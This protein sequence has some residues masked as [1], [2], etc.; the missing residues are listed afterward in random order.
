MTELGR[1]TFLSCF[2]T[3]PR[4]GARGSTRTEWPSTFD[5]STVA[6]RPREL[7][8]ITCMFHP[9]HLSSVGAVLLLILLTTTSASEAS[10]SPKTS[11]EDTSTGTA[12][13]APT[14]SSSPGKPAF[15]QPKMS[16][17]LKSTKLE[18]ERI[19][20]GGDGASRAR[21]EWPD[22]V[23]KSGEE[24]KA[25]ILSDD[26]TLTVHILPEGSMVTMDYRLD[27]V[28]I[29]VDGAGNVVQVPRKG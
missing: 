18:T 14:A 17:D 27:R 11:C 19:R 10:P 2:R 16:R 21:E 23:G 29:F 1:Q 8:P 7:S 15:V 5:E 3:G 6:S 26:S 28:R 13:T 20:G 9:L 4:G 22:L 12:L 24:A 25:A